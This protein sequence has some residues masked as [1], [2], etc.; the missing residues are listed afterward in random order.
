MTTYTI[1]QTDDALVVSGS[2]EPLDLWNEL[3]R[4]YLEIRPAQR[5][6]GGLRYPETTNADVRKVITVLTRE[7]GRVHYDLAT[8][9]VEARRWAKAA[10]R[11]RASMHGRGDDETF[12]DNA[13]FWAGD[14]KRLVVYLSVARY[15]PTRSEMLDDLRRPS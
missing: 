14:A 10:R 15:L 13:G 2:G 12:L 3:R 6:P 7:L 9:D 4:H 1:Q 8:Y 5:A 11:A